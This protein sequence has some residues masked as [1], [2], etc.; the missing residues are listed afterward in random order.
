VLPKARA[1]RAPRE[2][3]RILNAWQKFCRRRAAI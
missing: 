3:I 2:Y 1:D